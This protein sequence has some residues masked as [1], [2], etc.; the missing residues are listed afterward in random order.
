MPSNI[1]MNLEK[2]VIAITVQLKKT[3]ELAKVQKEKLHNH[4]NEPNNEAL[5]ENK[6]KLFPY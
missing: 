5:Y 4:S 1:K 3:T 2:H 6:L